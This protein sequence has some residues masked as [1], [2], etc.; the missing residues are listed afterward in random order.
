MGLIQLCSLKFYDE[1]NKNEK[2]W[3]RTKSSTIPS[4][5]TT[6]ICLRYSL[7]TLCDKCDDLALVTAIHGHRS[8]SHLQFNE[9]S[10]ET[11]TA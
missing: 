1:I 7:R 5:E 3:L 11:K 4:E 10:D 9:F 8:S 6:Q 2:H